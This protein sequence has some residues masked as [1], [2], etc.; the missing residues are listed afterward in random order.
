MR[1]AARRRRHARRHPRRA[2]G[3]KLCRHVR[4]ICD[5]HGLCAPHIQGIPRRIQATLTPAPHHYL[6]PPVP[7]H[8][9]LT[10]RPTRSPRPRRRC[11][12]RRRPRRRGSGP[13]PAAAAAAPAHTRAEARAHTRRGIRSR[14]GVH[15]AGPPLRVAAHCL[16]S[17]GI[18]GHLSESPHASLHRAP[19]TPAT[20]P[21][22]GRQ[23]C[24]G[25]MGG[26]RA[27]RL[28]SEP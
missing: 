2:P 20:A 18:G 4:R 7:I 25:A 12:P 1:H 14:P 24:P 3:H 21:G 28:D 8:T 6:A 11:R 26:D 23:P 22:S 15:A 19:R 27:R 10:H 9:T 17:A 5:T 13:R 16:R